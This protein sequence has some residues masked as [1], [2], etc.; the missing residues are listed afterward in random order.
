MDR[1]NETPETAEEPREP[2]V[3][4]SALGAEIE[5]GLAR[6][7]VTREELKA[8]EKIYP[9]ADD[10]DAYGPFPLSVAFRARAIE[11][12]EALIIDGM[13]TCIEQNDIW[14]AEL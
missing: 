12:L 5:A 2:G 4:E 13:D 1:E 14:I 8:E 3:I 7:G 9:D 10:D 11:I 6:L